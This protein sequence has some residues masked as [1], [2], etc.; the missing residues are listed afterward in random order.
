M[1]NPHWKALG[2]LTSIVMENL[3]V[4]EPKTSRNVVQ[5]TKR[6][7]GGDDEKGQENGKVEAFSHK[8]R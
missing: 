5:V 4:H 6:L 2:M 7:G 1:S 3:R 8:Q